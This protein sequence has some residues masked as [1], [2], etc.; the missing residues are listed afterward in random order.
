MTTGKKGIDLIKK[1]EGISLKPYLC[2]AN[3]PTIGY[4][5]TIYPDGTKVSMKDAP[6]TKDRAEEILKFVLTTF[7]RAV[8]KLVTVPITQNQFDALVS[9]TYNVGGVHLADST[10]LKMLNNG[11][12]AGASEQFGRWAKS[13]GKTLPGLVA[14][15]GSEKELF[16]TKS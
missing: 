8:N 12:Y 5:S 14:R 16:N 7:E 4:G 1:Y 13:A 11:D 10:L 6:I 3:I 9:F 15:R 2:P